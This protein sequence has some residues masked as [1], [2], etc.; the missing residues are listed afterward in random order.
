MP[1]KKLI[2]LM[3]RFIYIVL[4]LSYSASLA[5]P[6]ITLV[7]PQEG[8]VINADHVVVSGCAN[9]L[10]NKDGSID[11]MFVMGN[12]SSLLQTD[13][14]KQRFEAI[15]QLL[16]GLNKNIDMRI[17]MVFV[18]DSATLA[19]HLL[20]VESTVSRVINQALLL[21][22][23]T[24]NGTASISVGIDVA[25]K[26]LA[27]NGRSDATK[28]L[29][30]FTD[31]Q[32]DDPAEIQASAANA[33][34]QNQ[35][36]HAIAL[37]SQN[38]D[39]VVAMT[40]AGGG[41]AFFANFP[42]QLPELFRDAKLVNINNL[43]V[44][45][46]SYGFA[47]KKAD[48]VTCSYSVPIDLDVGENILEVAVADVYGNSSSTTVTVTVPTILADPCNEDPNNPICPTSKDFRPVKLRPQV[49][50]AGFDPMLIDF[51]DEEFKILA[52]V[53]ESSVPIKT[54]T[55][56]ENTGTMNI[57]MN[58]EGQLANG[59]KLYSASVK[60]GR[61]PDFEYANLFGSQLG[62][63]K[64]TAIDQMWRKH[65]FPH[66]EFGNNPISI[67]TPPTQASPYATRGVRRLSPQTLMVGFDPVMLDYA[68]TAFK[69]KAIVRKGS[70][71][72]IQYVTLKNSTESFKADMVLE[73]DIG[74][75]DMMYSLVYTYPRGAFP[76]STFADLF[77]TGEGEYIV[78]TSD[79]AQ[80]KHRF[81]ALQRGNFPPNDN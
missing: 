25:S 19:V 60:L 76:P 73:G 32:N 31:G 67:T 37:N 64:I 51:G 30:V 70:G 45:N 12:S 53:R 57:N 52:L 49:L 29:L 75:G 46:N 6:T 69:V 4:S 48:L 36:V 3:K 33:F 27:I 1:N 26:Y 78:E 58:L 79:A 81:P 43:T 41:Q 50:M 15:D 14:T 10:S 38:N 18:S 24:P 39:A 11:L 74:N 21:Q 66:L 77:G 8:E 28:I 20:S 68:D 22:H 80:Q 2:E 5:T 42:Q 47:T 44:T 23:F 17:G 72:E 16:N 35:I 63:F 61:G 7:E 13:P 62:E 9:A 65:S 34:A 59:D 71:G 55:A 54:V 56:S 40:Q